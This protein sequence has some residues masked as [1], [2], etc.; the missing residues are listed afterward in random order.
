MP[1]AG[2]EQCRRAGQV[3]ERGHQPVA[4]DRLARGA[5]Q[6]TRDTQQ[7]VLRPLDDGTA[8]RVAQQVAVV[9]G[10]QPEVLE[11]PVG[12]VVDGVVQLAGVGGHER[13]GGVADQ[14]LGM[15][16]GDALAERVHA[17]AADL[18]VDVGGQQAGGE[19]GVLRFL[20]DQLGRRPDRQAVELLG[21]GAVVEPA[22]RPGRHPQW[23]YCGHSG[24]ASLH[25]ADD[26]VHVDVLEL[27]TALAHP[28]RRVL[29]RD[30]CHGSPHELESPSPGRREREDRVAPVHGQPPRVR[31]PSLGAWR[32]PARG[33]DRRAGRSSD[34]RAARAGTLRCRH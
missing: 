16:E 21:G 25:R 24:G 11:A 7:P 13:R 22:D 5:R 19:P 15:A 27:T 31:T 30:D 18:L 17:L 3:C 14:P 29:D 28:H 4:A 2:V 9:D 6:S 10:A 26:L 1:G 8:V 12:V 33:A 23:V 34:S 20:G 32:P